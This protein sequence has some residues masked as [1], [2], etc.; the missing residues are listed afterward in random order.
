MEIFSEIVNGPFSVNR[1]TLPLQ[2]G[3]P[4]GRTL[5][6]FVDLCGQVI[7]EPGALLGRMSFQ[8]LNPSSIEVLNRGLS[9]AGKQRKQSK[10]VSE[11]QNH[12]SKSPRSSDKPSPSKNKGSDGFKKPKSRKEA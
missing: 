12:P 1:A 2:P 6:L 10:G 11:E 8:S 7:T 5:L 4:V 3:P 9:Q